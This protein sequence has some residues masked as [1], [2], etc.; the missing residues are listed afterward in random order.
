MGV[1]TV[2]DRTKPEEVLERAKDAE[3]LLTNKTV[4][5]AATLEQL[6]RLRYVGVLATGYNVVD[7]KAAREHGVTVTNIPAYSTE[8]VVQTVFAHILNIIYHVGHYTRQAREGVWQAKGDFSYWDSPLLELYGKRIGIVGMGN[9]GRAVAR[10]ARAFGMTIYAHTSATIAQLPA[11]TVKA[12]LETLFRECDIVTLHCPLRADN[13]GMVNAALLDLM[14]PTAILIN[15]ARGPL[16][17]EQDLADALRASK[18]RAAGVDVLSSEPPR[19][20]NPLL[21]A[22]NCFITPHIAWAT[23]D[24][25]ERLMAQ[26]VNNLRLFLRGTP[27]NVVE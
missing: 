25:R 19:A 7:V 14:K 17:N 21:T 1:C 24:A 23:L 13:A 12:D 20:D 26:A 22:P 27:V 15:T 16:V 18:L 10:V 11:G 5:D 3:V 8:S 9:I 4:L 2:Y 6:P